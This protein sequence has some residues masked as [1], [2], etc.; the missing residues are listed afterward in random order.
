MNAASRSPGAA[1]VRGVI[2]DSWFTEFLPSETGAACV[3]IARHFPALLASTLSIKPALS[4]GV[5]PLILAALTLHSRAHNSL[6]N[7]RPHQ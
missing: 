6:I 7:H 4:G 3:Y 2:G 1:N 5:P